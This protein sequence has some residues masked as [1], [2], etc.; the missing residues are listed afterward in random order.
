MS[1]NLLTACLQHRWSGNLRELE[2]FVKRFL[3]LGEEQV[4]MTDFSGIRV[5]PA[6]E[7]DNS[8]HTSAGGLKKLLSTVK[9]EVEARV[10]KAFLQRN[11]WKRKKT[12]A[13][14]KISYKAL[15]Y[16]MRQHDIIAPPIEASC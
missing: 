8:L 6:S 14:L 15:L 10:I 4:M 5:S 2:N 3:V 1:T 9:G 11:H 7:I 12:A 16:K 13:E